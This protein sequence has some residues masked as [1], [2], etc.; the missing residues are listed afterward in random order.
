[1]KKH[2]LNYIIV[3]SFAVWC[4]TH[5]FIISDTGFSQWKIGGFGMFSSLNRPTSRYILLSSDGNIGNFQFENKNL[6]SK[7]IYNLS[8]NRKLDL[9]NRFFKFVG[10]S[11]N[12]CKESQALL[13]FGYIDFSVENSVFYR[14]RV[15]SWP[16]C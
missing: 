2:W 4:V 6:L 1:M 9:R 5:R 12:F 14:K 11:E 13:E 3:A 10:D 15:T 8:E 16:L 7:Y